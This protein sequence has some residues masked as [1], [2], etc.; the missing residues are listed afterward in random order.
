MLGEAPTK[1]SV[2]FLKHI[3]PT[4]LIFWNFNNMY[5]ELREKNGKHYVMIRH[6]DSMAKPVAQFVSTNP[7]EAYNV[8][9][10]YAIQNKCL[11]R[12]T[13]GGTEIPESPP[14]PAGEG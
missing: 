5:I 9:K 2:Y 3:Y 6:D 10:Q 13:K 11:I 8:A 4:P 1:G 7:V 12:A 14:Q